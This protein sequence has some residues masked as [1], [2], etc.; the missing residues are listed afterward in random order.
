MSPDVYGNETEP[1]PFT[2][3]SALGE[4]QRCGHAESSARHL[5]PGDDPVI[6]FVCLRRGLAAMD[7]HLDGPMAVLFWETREAAEAWLDLEGRRA[8]GWHVAELIPAADLE[9]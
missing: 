3:G 6:G 7:V 4:C 5:Y 1:H 8:R 9:P 2:A